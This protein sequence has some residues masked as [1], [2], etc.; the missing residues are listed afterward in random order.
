[1]KIVISTHN[2]RPTQT[3]Q[4]R[5]TKQLNKL[6][7][8]IP[9]IIAAR[10]NIENDTAKQHVPLN[11]SAKLEIPG[12]DLF[13]EDTNINVCTA[14]DNIVKKLEQQARKLQNKAKYRNKGNLKAHEVED[15]IK[16]VAVA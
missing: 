13:A 2:I 11:C 1:M 15:H 3:I 5:I 9:N 14:V 16:S 8:L 12:L 6:E 4:D 10:I 7:R